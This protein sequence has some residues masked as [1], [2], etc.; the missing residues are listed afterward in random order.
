MLSRQL[1]HHADHLEEQLQ[2]SQDPSLSP[3]VVFPS[4]QIHGRDC[5][6]SSRLECWFYYVDQ[7]LH[8]PSWVSGILWTA[9]LEE[10]D[11][12]VELHRKEIIEHVQAKNL[13]LT[14][15]RKRL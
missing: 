6:S 3:A 7:S 13:T 8:R 1:Y 12:A 2:F 15:I 9:V 5:C 11:D 4:C 10:E 14:S